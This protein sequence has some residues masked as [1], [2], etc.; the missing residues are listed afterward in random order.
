MKIIHIPKEVSEKQNVCSH[1]NHTRSSYRF[2]RNKTFV[3]IKITHIHHTG[4]RET[5]RL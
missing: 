3:A 4:F 5:K 2:Q 1:E